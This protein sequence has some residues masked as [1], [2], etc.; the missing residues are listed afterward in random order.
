MG[1]SKVSL[2]IYSLGFGGKR[3]LR[4]NPIL[5]TI[6]PKGDFLMTNLAGTGPS[7]RESNSSFEISK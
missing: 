2:P 7:G 6:K 3:T 4:L 1:P 5:S